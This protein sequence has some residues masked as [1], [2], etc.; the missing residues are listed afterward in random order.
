MEARRTIEEMAIIY[1]IMD[2]E[3][4]LNQKLKQLDSSIEELFSGTFRWQE[5]ARFLEASVQL[6]EELFSQPGSGI[7]KLEFVMAVWNHYK[8]DYELLEQ[9]DNLINFRS[10]LGVAIGTIVETWDERAMEMLIEKVLIPFI[11]GRLFPAKD[12]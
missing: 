10:I 7:T 1:G 9:L 2:W 12:I 11:V 6:A 5:L 4:Q 8:E 3:D